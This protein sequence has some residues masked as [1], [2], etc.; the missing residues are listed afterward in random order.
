VP[1]GSSGIQPPAQAPAPA[2]GSG[3]HASSGG[4]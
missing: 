2:F 4:S 1:Q 3:S